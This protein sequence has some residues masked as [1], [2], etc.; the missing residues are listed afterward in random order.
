VYTS[1]P[2]PP[3]VLQGRKSLEQGDIGTGPQALHW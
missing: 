3:L 1:L 2:I